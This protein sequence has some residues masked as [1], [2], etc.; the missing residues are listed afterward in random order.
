MFCPRKRKLL[1]YRYFFFQILL[2]IGLAASDKLDRTYLPPPGAQFAG[3]S[4]GDIQAPLELPN[5]PQSGT[6]QLGPSLTGLQDFGANGQTTQLPVTTTS[7]AFTQTTTYPPIESYETTVIP[8][9]PVTG[10]PVQNVY[11]PN[12]QNLPGYTQSDGQFVPSYNT[13]LQTGYAPQGT[14]SDQSVNIGNPTYTQTSNQPGV[15]IAGGD[16]LIPVVSPQQPLINEGPIQYPGGQ[17]T[18]SNQYPN[19][20]LSPGG[21]VQISGS[22]SHSPDGYQDS[23]QY[24][25]GKIT[26]GQ[27]GLI[28]STISPQKTTPNTLP[29]DKLIEIGHKGPLIEEYPQGTYSGQPINVQDEITPQ[30]H[31][32]YENQGSLAHNGNQRPITENHNVGSTIAKNTYRPVQEDKNGFSTTP[33]SGLVS[34]TSAYSSTGPIIR[35]ERPQAAG[36]RNAVIIN[37]ENVRTPNS[38]FYSYDTSNGIH[39]DERG[40]VDDGTKAQGAYSYIGDDG[41]VYSVVYTADENGF[42]P[43]GDHI[44]TAPP[45][46][47]AI[48]KVI[49]Q[50]AR[51]KAAGIVD[52]GKFIK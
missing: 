14:T 32:N 13:N 21:T 7:Y 1:K 17:M 11:Q 10:L 4:P 37:Y 29:G 20:N 31:Q 34:S 47:E 50:A 45:I 48:Q 28:Q 41:K 26:P 42:Q 25:S 3:G 15:V 8:V 39:A 23:Q 33:V 35:P 16:N 51:D 46:P 6:V 2:A 49:E 5:L 9:N 38:Y 43:H 18:I 19:Q 44:P 52:D 24:T 30:L 36:D 27:Q 22:R 12:I 40:T